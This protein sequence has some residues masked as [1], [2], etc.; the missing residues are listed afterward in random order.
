MPVKALAGL[1]VALV[2][3]CGSPNAAI[4]APPAQ[5]DVSYGNGAF[6]DDCAAHTDCADR[7]CVEAVGGVG[8]VC[9]RGCN[10]DCPAEWTCREIS[11]DNDTPIRVCLPDAPQLCLACADDAECGTGAACLSIDGENSCATK[12]TSGCP[13]GY[14]CAADPGGTH[15]GTYCVPTTGSC[16]CTAELGGAT[17]ACTSTNTVGTCFGTQTCNPALGWSNCTAATAV[18]EGCDGTDNDCDFLIDEDTGGGQ[19]CTNTV[20]GIG[21]C[22]GTRQCG[23]SIGYVCEGQIP[24]G[25]LCNYA[26]EDCD[27]NADESFTGVGTV[28]SP[29]VGGC[30]RVGSIRCKTDGSGT[31]CSVTAGMPSSELCNKVDDDCDAKTDETFPNLTSSCSVGTGTCQRFGTTICATSGTTTTCS[32]Q[33]GTP[34]TELCNLLDDD[35]DNKTDEAFPNL[36][37]GCSVGVGTCQRFGTTVCASGGMSTTCSVT[38]GTPGMEL[39]NALDDD[40]DMKSDETF[41]NLATGCAVGIGACQRFG[42][43]VCASGGMTTTCSVTAGS[44]VAEQC[45]AIDDDCDTKTDEAFPTL[46]TGCNVG[47]GTCQRFGTTVCAANGSTTTCS[48]T[49]GTPGTESCNSLDDDCDTKTDETFPTLG[50]GCSA[51]LGVCQRF[52]TTVCATSGTTTT[53]SAMAGT[54][55][56]SETCNYLDD[57]CNGMVDNGFVNMTTGAYDQTANCGSCGNNCATV[58]GMSANAT[59]QCSTASGSPKCVMVCNAGTSDLNSSSFDGCEFVLD[60]TS[61]YVSTTDAAAVDDATCGIG[62]VGTGAGNH[63]CRTITYGLTRATAL[64]RANVRVA[65]GTYNESVT[66][67]SGKNLY[68]GYRPTTWDRHL[69]TTSTLIQGVSVS[70]N[71]DRTIVAVNVSNSI[72][73]GFVVRGSFNTKPTGNSYA[74]YVSGGASTLVITDNQ[75]FAGRGGPG[76][77]GAAGTNGTNGPDGAGSVNGS[78]DG[79]I[80]NNAPCSNALRQF[81]NGAVFSC[82][83]QSVSG[84]NGG[85]NRCPVATDFTQFSGLNGFAGATASGGGAGGAA[86]QG[87]FDGELEIRGG[88]GGSTCYLPAPPMTG[89]DGNPGG[90][91]ANAAGV[92]GCSASGGSVVGGEWTN[93]SGAAGTGGRHGGGGSGG[94]AGG[95]G[96][97]L[98]CSGGQAKDRLGAHGGGGGAG[99][100]GGTGGASGGAG[101]GV[102]GIFIVG[103]TAPTIMNNTI[104]RGAGGTGGDGGIGGAGGIGGRGGQGGASVMLC[105]GKAGA[106]GTGGNGGNGSGGGGGCGGSSYGIFTSGV[107]TPTYCT[108]NSVSG[109]SAGTGG[110]GGFS[111]GNPGGNGVA[112]ALQGCTSI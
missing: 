31:E 13:T 12:C 4:D 84:G 61:V 103:G 91:G 23:G 108:N 107:G 89:A 22:P 6:G 2:V 69:A 95:G 5:Q 92:A 17:R 25:E 97:C 48:A 30:Q 19:A 20:T 41:P 28:C 73:E 74:I 78:H 60:T 46:G 109:G 85:G 33:A 94:A 57:D 15:A 38:A 79:F 100:C 81:T 9:T 98:T 8:G 87:G 55:S 75:I 63:P 88:G 32:V 10:D 51:G 70:G 110:V 50:S 11:S 102:F 80:G 53:C 56:S 58:Y 18:L 86:S 101:G 59:G 39:C 54:N 52:G 83:G 1:L 111:G 42:T 72:L 96:A 26:D 40:C 3:A 21:T 47:I 71:H 45:N 24:S 34:A 27:G 82:G 105:S 65:D 77:E 29:G 67:V 7:Y 44:P 106:G 16:A 35:C 37:T 90:N 68:G 49:A 36:A 64:S 66:L 104:Q 62:P 76:S 112:G 93:G 14:T 43:T 99:A